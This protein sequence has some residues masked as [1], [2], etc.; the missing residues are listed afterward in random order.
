PH[1]PTGA[2][3]LGTAAREARDLHWNP[4]RHLPEGIRD[5]PEYGKAAAEKEEWIRRQPND[6]AERRQRFEVLRELTE[7]LQEPLRPAETA[8]AEER[9]NARAEAHANELL[10]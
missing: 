5:R 7:R 3:R 10:L 2:E 1:F 6:P 4:Q 8:M 9:R